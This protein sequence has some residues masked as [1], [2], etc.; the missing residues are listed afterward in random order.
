MRLVTYSVGPAGAVRVGVRVGHRVLDIEAA[1]RVKGEPLPSSLQ[2]L[3]VA[4]RGALSRVQALAKAATT[5]ARPLTQA[6]YEERAIRFLPPIPEVKS[7]LGLEDNGRPQAGEPA[8]QAS[9]EPAFFEMAA[10]GFAGH[11]AKLA[12]PAGMSRQGFGAELVFVVGR[13]AENVGTD[14][15]LDYV[16][17]VTLLNRFASRRAPGKAQAP[18]AIG[19]EIVTMD[20]IADPADLW[21]IATVNG[22]EFLRV[23]T[24]DQVSSL[25]EVLERASRGRRLEPGDLFSTGA[26]ACGTDAAGELKPGDVVECALEGVTMLR[27]TVAAPAQG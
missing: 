6:M 15:A 13:T 14:D 5:D 19:P 26:F 18:G 12:L 17:G 21:M 7:I 22:E 4:G 23:N 8:R 20:E 24:R 1:S 27:T 11:D 9:P 2:A 25:A 10:S 3:L 16:A